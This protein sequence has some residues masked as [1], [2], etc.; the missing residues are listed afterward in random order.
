M[1]LKALHAGSIR[2][3]HFQCRN[4]WHEPRPIQCGEALVEELLLRGRVLKVLDINLEPGVL[5]FIE[6]TTETDGG[7]GTV[8]DDTD[9]RWI[10]K[11]VLECHW[12]GQGA[13]QEELG[14]TPHMSNAGGSREPQ[15]RPLVT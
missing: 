3:R 8:S 14:E 4:R 9:A 15:R 6:G 7:L 2:G 13:N 1:C 11:N 12:A 10:R 5:K